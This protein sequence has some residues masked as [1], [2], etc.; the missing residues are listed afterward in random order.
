METDVIYIDESG[1]EQE[2]NP[3]HG[4]SKR[5][6]KLYQEITGRH[7]KRTNAIAGYLNGIILALCVYAML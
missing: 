2:M 6:V 4:R 3:T 7:I 1:V 5:G